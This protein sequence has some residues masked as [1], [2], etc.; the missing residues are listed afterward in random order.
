MCGPD[1]H[2]AHPR[3]RRSRVYR[4]AAVPRPARP[5]ARGD[6]PRQ[7]DVRR[8]ADSALHHPPE[9]RGRARR[10]PRSARGHAARGAGR[11]GAAPR[12]HRRLPGLR[13]RSDHRRDDQRRRH[14]GRGRGAVGVTA[15]GLRQHR[16]DL[17]PLRDGGH[18]GHADQPADALRALQARRRAA[19]GRQGWRRAPL[20]DGLRPQPAAAPR[21]PR[22]RLLLPGLPPQTGHRVRGPSPADLP[23]RRGTPPPSTRSRSITTRRCAATSTTSA[24]RT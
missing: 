10:R 22:Q 9:A 19:G 7:P 5:R 17:R 11:R 13:R 1:C 24:P 20:R 14:A 3:H 2:H 23:A 8:A 21:R 6:P 16:I 4:I 18:G 15:A 12:C